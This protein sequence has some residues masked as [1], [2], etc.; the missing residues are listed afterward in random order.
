MSKYWDSAIHEELKYEH[1]INIIE[2]KNK[3]TLQEAQTEGG[4]KE[5]FE[6]GKENLE[7]NMWPINCWRE[8]KGRNLQ[9]KKAWAMQMVVGIK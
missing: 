2:N 1:P 8:R 9:G 7:H 6:L 4:I 5:N 3:I